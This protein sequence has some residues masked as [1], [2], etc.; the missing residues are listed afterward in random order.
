MQVVEAGAARAGQRSGEI[1]KRDTRR[2]DRGR[3]KRRRMREDRQRTQS[4][5][6]EYR[7]EWKMRGEDVR[8][9]DGRMAAV[10]RASFIVTQHLICFRH[11]S[12]WPLP[13]ICASSSAHSALYGSSKRKCSREHSSDAQAQREQVRERASNSSSNSSCA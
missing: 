4:K 9:E 6:G 10:P 3:R 13:W 1:V 8:M 11:N 5:A 7:K 12:E 2:H